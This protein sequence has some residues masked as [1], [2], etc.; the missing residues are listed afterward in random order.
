[1]S[2][3]SPITT[4]R[5]TRPQ[6]RAQLLRAAAATFLHAGYDGTSVEAVAEH[7][8]VTRLIVYRVFG[9]K[10]ELYSAVLASVTE[11]LRSEFPPAEFPPASNPGSH[12]GFPP[13]PGAGIVVTVLGV[14]RAEPD[15]F[16]LLWRH[17]AHE[18]LFAA[19][20][21]AFREVVTAYTSALLHAALEE[22][23]MRIWAAQSLVNHLYDGVC[24]WLD[25]GD[26]DRDQ[27]FSEQMSAG[28]RALVQAWS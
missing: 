4:P 19:D 17:A 12:H 3:V 7:A 15:A 10:R 18:P 9:S 21:L 8:G 16:R 20:A 1:M 23:V 22:P 25:V 11:R 5:L 2:A 26:P 14:A 28:L 6:R 13:A 24:G 27:Q